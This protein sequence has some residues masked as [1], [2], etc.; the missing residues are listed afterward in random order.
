M[1]RS[2]PDLE[3]KVK[4]S[5]QAINEFA[6]KWNGIYIAFSG[7][8]DSAALLFLVAET[9]PKSLIRGVVFV[10][11]TENTDQCNISYVYRTV[12]KLGLRE[13][14][15]HLKRKDM[16]FFDALVKWGVPQRKN[17]W[18]TRSSRC[19]SSTP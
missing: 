19:A 15:L 3:Q 18:C 8:K 9:L 4:Q 12:D 11:V 16:N 5:Q 13:K 10:E 14:L 7:G 6:R 2:A 17:R 1:S